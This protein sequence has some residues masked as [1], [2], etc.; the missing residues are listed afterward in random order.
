MNTWTLTDLEFKVLCDTRFFGLVPS[1]FSITSRIPYLDDY[2]REWRRTRAELENRG[3]SAFEAI[4][5][6]MVLPEV[7]V[8]GEAWEDSDFDNPNKRVRFYAGRLGS[9][10][11]VVVQL[12]GETLKHAEGFTITA[13]DPRALGETVVGLLPAAGPGRRGPIEIEIGEGTGRSSGGGSMVA[14]DDD[15]YRGL[16]SAAFFD[17]PAAHTGTVRLTQG[18]SKFG[19]RG[20]ISVARLWRDLPDDGRYVIPLEEPAPVAVGMGSAG[21]ADWIDTEAEHIVQRMND[22]QEVD[23]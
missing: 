18:R 10:G 7:L 11:F 8:G 2:E 13:C 4:V 12:P 3:D 5:D 15:D 14:D 16:T 17:I 19:P 1:M 9:R 21:L 22:Y 20:R 6:T 23:E